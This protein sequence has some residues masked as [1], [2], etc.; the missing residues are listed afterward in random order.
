MK[1]IM[2]FLSLMCAT[3]E[4]AAAVQEV[5]PAG[6]TWDGSVSFGAELD[7]RGMPVDEKG[8][9]DKTARIRC[10]FSATWSFSLHW[11]T[12][13]PV[14]NAEEAGGELTADETGLIELTNVERQKLKLPALQADPRRV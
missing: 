14:A 9:A 10:G 2:L 7:K 1:S 13:M 3:S 12:V 6:A 11:T 5:A 8:P 4:I